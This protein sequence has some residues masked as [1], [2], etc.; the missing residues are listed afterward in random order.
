[1]TA[2]EYPK[3]V[4]QDPFDERE[5]FEAASRGY[6][7]TALVQ[8]EDGTTYS[9]SFYDC[10]R[11][12]Q[13]LEYEVSAGRMWLADPGM[14][15]LPEVTLENMSTAIRKLAVEGYFNSLRPIEKN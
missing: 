5:Q 9:V 15:V 7:S 3:L 8:Q 10:V 11:L 14:I 13:D 4:F 2:D 6:L 12:G 1:M